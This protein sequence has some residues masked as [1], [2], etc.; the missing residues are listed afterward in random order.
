MKLIAKNAMNLLLVSM[1]LI[2]THSTAQTVTTYDELFK[3][4]GAT[5][6]IGALNAELLGD[7]F[8]LYDG[9][10]EFVQTDVSLPGNNA[11]P[12]AAGRRFQ[13]NE[14]A[15]IRGH[16]GEWDL[17]IP[18][19][20]GVFASGSKNQGWTVFT[21]A[22]ADYRR[23]SMNGEP[24]AGRA[25]I[26]SDVTFEPNE[27]WSGNHLYIPGQGDQELLART[28]GN[29]RSPSD[30][31]TWPIITKDGWQFSCINI[32]NPG[33]GSTSKIQGEGMLARAP[34]GT[35]YRFDWLVNRIASSLKKSV[36][37]Q[38][39]KP[40]AN[41][42]ALLERDEFWLLPTKDTDRFGNT[43]TYSYDASNPWRL[44]TIASSD[45]RT[46]TFLYE[47]D[48]N[49]PSLTYRIKEISDG[50]RKW[51]YSYDATLG[52][53]SSVTQADASKWVFAIK[54]LKGNARYDAGHSPDCTNGATQFPPA[55]ATGTITHPSGAVGTF[56]L[57]TVANGRSQ[58]T[59][60]CSNLGGSS[61][62]IYFL[63]RALVEKK[64]SGPGLSTTTWSFTRST[65]VGSFSTC[66]TN[67]GG[68][69]TVTVADNWGRATRHTFGTSFQSNEGQ[70]QKIEQGS[71]VASTS[72]LTPLRT[73][74]QG[75]GK[76]SD[77]QG[78]PYPDKVGISYAVGDKFSATTNTPLKSKITTQQ[79]VT[80]N[81]TANAFDEFAR[82]TSVT[83]SS[84][85]GYSR[86]EATKYKDWF[87]T[88][89]APKWILGQVEEVNDVVTSGT[90]TTL[91]PIEQ[92]TFDANTGALLN[93]KRFGWRTQLLAYDTDGTV[94]SVKDAADQETRLSSYMRGIP[95]RI[96]YPDA[97]FAKAVVN[98]IGRITSVTNEVG[99]AST[100][101]YGYD[102]MGRLSRITYPAEAVAYKSTTISFKP[103]PA[104]AYGLPIGH[105][106]QTVVTGNLTEE[107]YFD[108]LWRPIVSRRVDTST[109]A[110]RFVVK[111]FNPDGKT[112]FESYPMTALGNYADALVGTATDYDALGRPVLIRQS[113]ELDILLTKIDYLADFKTQ[114]INPRDKTSTTSY[115]AF[116]E[117][118]DQWPVQIV[119]DVAKTIITRNKYGEPTNM[120]RQG[121]YNNATLSTSRDYVYDTYHRLCKLIEPETGA[122]V[123][124]YD[125]AGNL[126]WQAD[127]QNLP[128]KTKC[129]TTSP[130]ASA[131]ATHGYDSRNRHR[132]TSYGDGVTPG[133]TKTWTPDGLVRTLTKGQ[134]NWTYD[135]NNRRL[136]K[137]ERLNLGGG[138]YTITREYN[139]NGHL[140]VLGYPDGTTVAQS[141][142]AFGEQTQAGTSATGG[143]RYPDGSLGGFTYGNGVVRSIT[144]NTR[145]LPWVVTDAIPGRA[146]LYKDTLGYDKN[147]NVLTITDGVGTG[148]RSRTMGYDA[149]DRMISA[150]SAGQWGNASYS[151]D[152]LDNLRSLTRTGQV[153]SLGYNAAT[154]RINS[155][156][157]NGAGQTVA[158]NARGDM[159]QRGTLTM[160]WD[161]EGRMKASP[162]AGQTYEYDG[163][164]RRAVVRWTNGV[165]LVQVYSQKGE[166]L[167]GQW[168]NAAGGVDSS[169]KYH[170]MDGKAVLETNSASSPAYLHTDALGS[171]VL[172]T[173]SSKTVLSGTQ[174]DPWGDHYAGTEPS[175]I[176]YTG[177]V[178]DKGTGLVQMQQRYYDPLIGRFVSA[179][180]VRPD[181]AT[182][183]NFNRYWYANNSPYKYTD[184]DGRDVVFAVD[185]RAA[186]GNGHTTLYFQDSKGSW[187]AYDQFAAGDTKSSGNFGFISGQSSKAG[188]SITP[189]PDGS[190]PKDGFR[191]KTTRQQDSLIAES[192]NQSAAAHNSGNEK[193]NLYT[194]NCTDAA[195]AVV[196]KSGAGIT[197]MNPR[198]TVKPNSWIK[199]VKE[200][201]KPVT[202]KDEVK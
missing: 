198:T 122:T 34:D 128:D 1:A 98:N 28:S 117:P 176:G 109:S 62:P 24:P 103:N 186:G 92:N 53:L 57:R 30:L 89:A 79:G 130:V 26:S 162:S 47:T 114:T 70:L 104:A 11:L 110:N 4:V 68:T 108:A 195:V 25:S 156:T 45:G 36:G 35:I 56:K 116:D 99:A 169:T 101:S 197:V 96:D 32:A 72:T 97:T 49:H 134:T 178:N 10:L 132:S 59:T 17:E 127:G 194:N 66:T 182:A 58:V 76:K 112:L 19:L 43:V 84:T 140:N 193:Y 200:S 152:P 15:I 29:T 48:V 179:D 14:D 88:T 7:K 93:T 87:G 168:I 202:T 78:Q 142:N 199:E 144:R 111:Q 22:N 172:R 170:L 6:T 185:P 136:L 143:W 41:T 2:A 148:V 189:M 183:G 149:L 63:S 138:E 44:L 107:T 167:Y 46:L 85:L 106:V 145:F 18:R 153:V 9:T 75:Y 21:G 165:Q 51:T 180:P 126:L 150:N 13:T 67:C 124:D 95:Q 60:T 40:V 151:Y 113:S 164:G 31:A 123:M 121:T 73:V 80:F 120:V 166:L 77:G 86:T 157:V 42:D 65:P 129:N 90:T 191:I 154:N 139:E 159:T 141:P 81:W 100:T 37:P 173:N 23:C 82:P 118:T 27:F 102:T 131:K 190:L 146:T 5:Q 33:S 38:R 74:T 52:T 158:Y 188:V 8:N 181:A 196:N 64:L 192:A 174:Y 187:K 83:R 39:R 119:N 69:K 91:T 3:R 201:P 115:Q 184:P 133:I 171:P 50:T 147:A 163:N 177:H 175:T 16:F 20:H 161:A 94:K 71:W 135:Y 160:S 55:E 12:V 125:A 54:A 105:W 137:E 155:L 61:N